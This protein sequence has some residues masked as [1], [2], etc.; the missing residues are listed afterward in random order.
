MT[1]PNRKSHRPLRRAVAAAIL[2]VGLGVAAAVYVDHQRRPGSVFHPRV[3][4]VAQAPTP[5]PGGA[6][7]A[8]WPLYGYSKDHVRVAPVPGR[9]RPPFRR[10]WTA[11]GHALLEFPPV[12]DHHALYQLDDDGVVHATDT[13]TGRLL[14]SRRLGTLA[15]SSPAASGNSVYVTL[16]EYGHGTGGR[17]AALRQ[18]D[19]RIR[20]I[21]NL[22]SRSESSPLLDRG[23]IYLGSE[24]G[25]VY[26]LNAHSGGVIWTY[27]AQGAVKAS[28]T[29]SA[30][31]L[32]FGD[33]GG[34]VQAIRQSDGRRVWITGGNGLIGG[35]TFYSTPA[36]IFGR[37]Y[38]G[39]TDGRVYAYD[40]TDGSLAWAHQTGS[41]VYSS[42]AVTQVNRVGP[43]VYIGSYDGTFYALNAR[44]GAVRWRYAAGGRI[45]GSPTILGGLVYFAVLGTHRTVALDLR[46]G[47]VVYTRP[48]GSFDPVVTDG[49]RIYLSGLTGLFGLI[50][51]GHRR[52]RPR[53]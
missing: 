18:T 36:A 35:G 47:H 28:P 41:Y 12:I 40:A 46:D 52:P 39:S 37:I 5:P 22:P 34:H 13:A 15:A 7:V 20:W 26:A 50:P 11:Y 4:F 24:N 45:S 48:S 16:L 2:L 29:L 9:M 32:Y 33:Y 49:E 10:L 1:E 53:R 3:P 25:T 17:V 6:D 27:H 30:G 31:R 51:T 21:R 44:S 14:W 38:L 43:T 42:P 8:P 19:G 23:R